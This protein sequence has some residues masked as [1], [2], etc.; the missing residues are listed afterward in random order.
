MH[1]PTT[2]GSGACSNTN[3]IK[4]KKPTLL[5]YMHT[6]DTEFSRAYFQFTYSD[7]QDFF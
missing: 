4:L 1:I 3:K 2:E 5:S 7:G 6:H